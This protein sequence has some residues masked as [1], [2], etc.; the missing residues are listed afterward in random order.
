RFF[1]RDPD[2]QLVV[3]CQFNDALFIENP[4]TDSH[5]YPEILSTDPVEQIAY[6]IWDTE[7]AWDLDAE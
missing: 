4:E 3:Q 7:L 5:S 1:I 6:P 2:C